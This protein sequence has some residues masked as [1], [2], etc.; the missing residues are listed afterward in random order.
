MTLGVAMH[1]QPAKPQGWSVRTVA[2]RGEAAFE[3]V[4]DEAT[5]ARHART[6]WGACDLLGQALGGENMARAR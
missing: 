4:S 2:G 5:L 6:D 3:A 1:Q